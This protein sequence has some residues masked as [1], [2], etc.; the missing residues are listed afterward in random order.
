MKKIKKQAPGVLPTLFS[1]SLATQFPN[2]Y[3]TNSGWY[4]LYI[5][6]CVEQS[7]QWRNVNVLSLNWMENCVTWVMLNMTPGVLPTR[8]ILVFIGHI[9]YSKRFWPTMR[10]QLQVTFKKLETDNHVFWSSCLLRLK[11]SVV[12]YIAYDHYVSPIYKI[13]ASF[14]S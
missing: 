8:M 6:I 14:K 9:P 7:H 2:W 11:I 13:D 12:I 10:E 3:T 5:L 1:V 4:A